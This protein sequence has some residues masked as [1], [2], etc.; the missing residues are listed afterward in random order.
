VATI[1]TINSTSERLEDEEIAI[2]L[3]VQEAA[4]RLNLSPKEEL[5]LRKF[6]GKGG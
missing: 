5:C 1:Q 6:H 2:N 4:L 3:L